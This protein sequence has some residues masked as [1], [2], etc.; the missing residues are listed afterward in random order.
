MVP[1]EGD[2]C[3]CAVW[4]MISLT[5]A[6]NVRK[7]WFS[8]FEFASYMIMEPDT[9]LY[10]KVLKEKTSLL[11]IGGETAYKSVGLYVMFNIKIPI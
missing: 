11:G 1:A 9:C 10:M 4:A 7:K 8:E 6:E 3:I 5:H 2:C